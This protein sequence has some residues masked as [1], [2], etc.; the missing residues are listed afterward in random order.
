M[1]MENQQ[2]LEMLAEYIFLQ[3]ESK[4]A[5]VI[6]ATDGIPTEGVTR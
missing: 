4:L 1:V 2:I 5:G 3:N 6:L